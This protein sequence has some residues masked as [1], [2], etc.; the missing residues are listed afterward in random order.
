MPKTMGRARSWPGLS[1]LNFAGFLTALLVCVGMAMPAGATSITIP[2]T[3]VTASA[4]SAGNDGGTN[5]NQGVPNSAISNSVNSPD[6]ASSSAAAIVGGFL[7]SRSEV[8]GVSGTQDSTAASATARWAASFSTIG[9]DPGRSV[10]I[11]FS[12]TIDG[13]LTQFNNNSGASLNDIFA[14]VDLT[15]S[16]IGAAGTTS[17][18]DGGARLVS[19]VRVPFTGNPPILD[20]SGDWADASRDG[21]FSVDP[22]CSASACA[23]TVDALID[24]DDALFVDFGQVFSVEL[25][26]STD[27][28]MF[29]GA[30]VGASALFAN[31]ASVALS[32][33][34]P[35]VTV[36][37]QD[38]PISVPEPGSLLLF[39]G[40]LIGL[41]LLRRRGRYRL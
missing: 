39:G 35:G 26:L 23:V 40:G 12:A 29:A 37:L 32:T 30:E 10:D 31:T 5:S 38:P 34:T 18:F 25:S 15:L 9:A 28:F 33:T 1:G 21:D 2:G 20:R 17:I 16:V 6:S 24:L 13:R 41:G 11:D 22:G 4:R 27:A 8:E 36:A 19:A 3:E 14:G 7:R